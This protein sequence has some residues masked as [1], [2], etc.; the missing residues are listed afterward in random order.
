MAWLL[1][2]VIAGSGVASA[3]DDEKYLLG[4]HGVRI[5]LPDDWQALEWSDAH[6]QAEAGDRSLKLFVWATPVQ[7]VP[8]ADGLEGWTG[9]HLAQAERIGGR[10][11][12]VAEAGV[13]EVAGRPTARVDLTFGYTGGL[14]GAQ[15]GATFA[16]LGG[17]LHLAVITAAQRAD[18][19]HAMVDELLARL[20]V[21]RP[22]ADVSGPQTVDAAG[23]AVTLPEGWRVPLE[24]ELGVVAAAAQRFGVEDL[25]PCWSAVRPHPGAD[26][27]VMVT[28]AAPLLLGVVDAYSFEAVDAVLHDKL[29][30]GAD[31]PEAEALETADGRTGFLFRPH[32]GAHTLR[33][34]VVPHGEGIARTWVF[35][36]AGQEADFDVALRQVL[37]T[38]TYAGDHPVGPADHLTY[39]LTYRP[40]SPPVLG[41]GAAL[42]ALLG[43]LGMLLARGGRK[44][45]YDLD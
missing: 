31:V 3:S 2:L 26:A 7:L 28:C 42:L 8:S 38:A 25:R 6:L 13:V 29:F 36:T 22:P 12:E 1:A 37:T 24:P 4:D 21:R 5:D 34:G 16:V 30:K 41:A 33:I 23:V 14:R 44:Q 27:D 35:G 40:T 43:G 11:P 32:P 18:K 39:W 20:E 9:V 15:A 10:E 45:P 17:D 19:A